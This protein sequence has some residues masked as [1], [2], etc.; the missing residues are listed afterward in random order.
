MWNNGSIENQYLE[1]Y[2]LH[3]SKKNVW[4]RHNAVT[5]EGEEFE[6]DEQYVLL[7]MYQDNGEM[8]LVKLYGE[9]TRGLKLV[10]YNV[11]LDTQSV[12]FFFHQRNLDKQSS[13]YNST[14]S[15][16]GV[17]FFVMKRISELQRYA[18]GQEEEE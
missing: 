15:M 4:M 6:L 10:K 13:L 17:H 8:Q 12:I 3:R 9:Q 7:D 14:R 1:N 5:I 16:S 18:V 11:S 2:Y